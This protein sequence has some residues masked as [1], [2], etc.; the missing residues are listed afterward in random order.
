MNIKGEHLNEF[1][2]LYKQHYGVVLSDKEALE[3]GLR[4]VQ[5]FAAIA[6]AY[7][8]SQGFKK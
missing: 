8:Q 2:A 3:M 1:K 6:K 7:E 4:L 5:L